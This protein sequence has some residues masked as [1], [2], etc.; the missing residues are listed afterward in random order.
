MKIGFSYSLKD[1]ALDHTDD[2][3]E[4]ESRSTIDAITRVLAKRGEVVH[5]P[6]G[7]G[8]VEMVGREHLDWVFNIAE[9]WGG[10][11]RESFV[12]AI[13]AALD[14]PYTG[15]DAVAL[16]IT[17]DKALTKRALRDAGVATAE[18]IVYDGIPPCAPPFGFPA[19]VKPNCDGSSRGVDRDSL[20]HDMEGLKR[21]TAAILENHQGPALVEPYLDGR[22]FCVGILGNDRRILKTCEVLLGHVDGIPFFSREYK[23]CETDRLEMDPGVTPAI[24]R[25][26]ERMAL[27]AWDVIGCRDYARFDFRT[28]LA[29]KPYLLEV[30]A[31]PGLSPVSGIFIHQA[32]MSGIS[33]QKVIQSI[34][35]RAE[36]EAGE[37]MHG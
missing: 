21:K 33:F 12:P 28:D 13:C 5:L 17:M 24:L 20:V 31:L 14:I 37:R 8:I 35:E 25:R 34:L 11:D 19:F 29:G 27:A 15:S 16:G 10:R 4:Y 36:R 2:H 3:A 30:N 6:C 26:M 18:F 23:R 7:P 32:E 1:P 9:G 22:D